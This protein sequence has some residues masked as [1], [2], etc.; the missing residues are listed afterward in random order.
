MQDDDNTN[1][2]NSSDIQ[3]V[4]KM[5]RWDEQEECRFAIQS[6]RRYC[7]IYYNDG[8]CTN[9]LAADADKETR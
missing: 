3:S 5:I 8:W 7:C 1:L 4:C 2:C 6:T 9:Y